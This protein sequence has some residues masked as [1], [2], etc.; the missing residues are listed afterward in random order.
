MTPNGRSQHEHGGAP[1][2]LRALQAAVIGILAGFVLNAILS[3]VVLQG[4]G[5]GSAD[6]PASECRRA[7]PARDAATPATGPAVGS[8]RDY[9]ERFRL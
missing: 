7:R 1:I 6:T 8:V 5:I 9:T 2:W 3:M 4:R